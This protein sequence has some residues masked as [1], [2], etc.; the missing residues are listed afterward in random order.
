MQESEE[1]C[2]RI[3]DNGTV[4]VGIKD[5]EGECV[6][7]PKP[8]QLVTAQAITVKVH[9]EITMTDAQ[10]TAWARLMDLT[11][12]VRAKGMV[13]NLQA[14]AADTVGATLDRYATVKVVQR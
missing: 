3:G 14:L 9:L 4:C 12:P 11:P 7:R 5:H 13:V 8:A 2:P 1:G 6:M 10:A